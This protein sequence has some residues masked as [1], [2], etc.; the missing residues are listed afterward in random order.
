MEDARNP[1][2]PPQ[3]PVADPVEPRPVDEHETFIPN[4]R[5]VSLLQGM[6]WLGDAWRMFLARPGKWIVTFLLFILLYVVLSWVPFANLVNSL[7]WPFIAAGIVLCADLQRRTGTFAVDTL[8]QGFRRPAPL[9][10]IGATVLLS[11]GV[12]Y[13][14]FAIVTGVEGANQ[15]VLKAN[16]AAS[17]ARMSPRDI[18]SALLLYMV[19]VLPISAATY[20]AAPLIMFQRVSVGTAIKM[21][22]M[23]SIKNILPA[24]LFG[25]CATLF[26]IVSI[27]PLGLGLLVSVPVLMITNYTVYRDVFIDSR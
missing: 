24:I 19:L 20:F 22:F 26:V 11:V 5:R 15:F 25:V 7:L 12:L 10:A 17:A 13:V 14:S 1:Y 9:L 18:W 6:R 3:A 16:A 27:I 21:S 4:G 8:F 23:G 2:A